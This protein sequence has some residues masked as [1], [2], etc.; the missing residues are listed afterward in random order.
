MSVKAKNH[1]YIVNV[2]KDAKPMPAA[3]QE[4]VDEAKATFVRLQKSK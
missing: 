3:S 1:V 4:R 2:K